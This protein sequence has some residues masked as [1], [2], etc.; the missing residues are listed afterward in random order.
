MDK[1]DWELGRCFNGRVTRYSDRRKLAPRLAKYGPSVHSVNYS[2]FG[3]I[4][5]TDGHESKIDK[6]LG[7]D[8][9]NGRQGT[10]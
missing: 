1:N 4:N 5:S 2:F 7:V 8:R 9:E 3:S 6:R 10:R